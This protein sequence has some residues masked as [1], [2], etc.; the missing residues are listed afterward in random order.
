MHDTVVDCLAIVDVEPSWRR[1]AWMRNPCR[2]QLELSPQLKVE[3]TSIYMGG[4]RHEAE[5]SLA[6]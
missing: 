3:S 2:N 1:L 5:E 6:F 4:K